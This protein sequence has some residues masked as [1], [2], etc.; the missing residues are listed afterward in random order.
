[1]QTVIG[2]DSW[3][4]G[5]HNYERL[6]HAFRKNG[7]DLQLLHIGSWGG[8]VGRPTEETIGDLVVR[9]VSHYKNKSLL[10]ILDILKPSAVVFLS[11]EV[12]AHRAFNRYSALR[13][14][15][16]LH[17]YHGLVEI[18]STHGTQMYKAGLTDRFIFVVSRIPKALLKIWPLY[19]HALHISKASI[20]DWR[21]FVSDIVSLTKGNYIPVSAPDSKASVCAV[22]TEADVGHAIKKY[23]YARRDV[24]VVGNPDLSRFNLISDMLGC[25]AGINQRQQS[26]EIVYI[27]TGLMYAGMVFNNGDDYLSHLTGLAKTLATQGLSLAI[28]LHPDHHR[29]E[30]PMRIADAG[31][32]VINSQDFLP[33]LL[34]CRAAM[35]EPSTAALIPAL[36]GLPLLMVAFGKL[37][38]QR[39]GKV[40]MDYPRSCLLSDARLVLSL[41]KKISSNPAEGLDAWIKNNAGPLPADDM[42]KRVA[43]V[44]A[45]QVKR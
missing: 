23:G 4:G 29:T 36:L 32:R 1:M 16:T 39:Y 9:D 27:D 45:Q 22:Y 3:T 28:K 38:G 6:V 10:E 2:F 8:D 44:V 20:N 19:A 37:E 12:F 41:I 31:I 14:I 18:Q 13:N 21:R 30:F 5:A 15:P 17:L 42:A 33:S 43:N 7:F 35:V 40:L 26:E 24:H 25:C 11:T 34:R